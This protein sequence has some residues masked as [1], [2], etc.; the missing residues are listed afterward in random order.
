VVAKRSIS[1]VKFVP[2]VALGARGGEVPSDSLAIAAESVATLALNDERRFGDGIGDGW[3]RLESGSGE[4]RGD[5]IRIEIS[6]L[7]EILASLA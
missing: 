2:V 3:S 7:D 1:G 6:D 4:N 5:S